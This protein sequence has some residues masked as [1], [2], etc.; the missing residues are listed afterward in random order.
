MLVSNVME[1]TKSVAAAEN[2]ANRLADK[3]RNLWQENMYHGRTRWEENFYEDADGVRFL[4]E[5]N[6]PNL[7][8]ID[9]ILKWWGSNDSDELAGD[10]LLYTSPSPRD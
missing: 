4:S 2:M 10:C 8:G 5:E 9:Y 3:V 1:K 6:F 7:Q